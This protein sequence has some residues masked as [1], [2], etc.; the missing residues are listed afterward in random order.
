MAT[1]MI[2][3]ESGH[4]YYSPTS[5]K[6]KLKSSICCFTPVRH[7]I[8]HPDY[9]SDTLYNKP[10]PRSSWIH[11][12]PEIRDRCRGFVIGRRS[13]G[14]RNKRSGYRSDDFRYD[15]ESYSLNFED[16]ANREAE[17]PFSSFSARLPATPERFS[18]AAPSQGRRTEITGWS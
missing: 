16:G 4:D 11:L 14:A 13:S 1:P 7:Q 10:P 9:D 6:N 2:T 8:L 3:N 5:F 15:P 12:D 18:T 17:L